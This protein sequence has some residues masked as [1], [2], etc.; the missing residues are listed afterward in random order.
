MAVQNGHKCS[1][2]IPFMLDETPYHY[3]A[4]RSVIFD[5]LQN[6]EPVFYKKSMEIGNTYVYNVAASFDIETS[7]FR[8]H[9]NGESKDEM[10]HGGRKF[11]TMYVWQFS[12]NGRVILGRTWDEFTDFMNELSNRFEL[13]PWKTLIVYVHNLGYEFQFIR[14]LFT[15]SKVFSTAKREPIYAKCTL[16]IEFRD[17][18]ILTAKSLASAANDLHK[19]KVKKMIGDLDYSKVRSS[20]TPLTDAE[21]GYC[22]HDD[23]VV[24]AI[25]QEKIEQEPRGIAGIPL[26]NTGYV[27]RFIRQKCYGSG[28]RHGDYGRFIQSLTLEPDEYI[29][30]KESFQ[31]GFTHA[32]AIYVNKKL[33]GVIDSFDFTSSYPAVILSEKFPMGKCY[34]KIETQDDFNRMISDKRVGA[35]FKIYFHNIQQKPDVYESPLSE[36]KCIAIS[37]DHI[38]NNGRIVSATDVI[39]RMTDIDFTVFRAFYKWEWFK[40]SEIDTYMMDYLPKPIIESVIELYEAKTVLKGVPESAVD[41]MVKKGMLNSV[42]GCMVTDIVKELIPYDNEWGWDA[43]SEDN[44]TF[45]EKIEK[46]NKSYNRFLYYPWGVW[47]TAYARRNLFTGIYAFGEDY[48]YSDTDSIKCLNADAHMKFIKWYN[49][50]ITFKVATV[51]KH[52]GINPEKAAPKTIKGVSKQIGV[53][54]HETK[55]NPYTEFKT[56]GAKRYIY[57]EGGKLHI[58]I[59]GLP[60]KNGCKYISSQNNPYNFFNDGMLI[61]AAN[62]GKLISTY[63]DDHIDIVNVDYMGNEFTAHEES[64]I[65]ME[66]ATFEM[67]ESREFKDYLKGIQR[68]YII[69]NEAAN[70]ISKKQILSA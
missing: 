46:Y 35:N 66:S 6:R 67:S 16:G 68:N 54:D 41:Y 10:S 64:A 36:S 21:M 65:H 45:E 38:T 29:R 58:T 4:D 3:P 9:I 70:G 8:Q 49:D 14:K 55:N 27:R 51:L 28:R 25:I 7:S 47:V 5:Q 32:N 24:D 44:S 69:R 15:W 19:Y 48:V 60:K 20:A 31:G 37:K 30:L 57:T 26:T 1:N 34:Y 12:I 22:V 18:Y 40:V 23:L 61:P 52:Y 43:E 39:T 53:W 42:Y 62:T 13:S 56:C 33:T 11:A 17:S 59:A 50:Q 63:I 2:N